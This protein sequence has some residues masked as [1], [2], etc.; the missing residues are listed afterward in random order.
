MQTL[1]F[2]FVFLGLISLSSCARWYSVSPDFERVSRSHKTIAVLPFEVIM[3][4]R[5]PKKMSEEEIIAIEEAEAQAFQISMHDEM[6]RSLRNGRFEL[7]ATLLSV[8]ETNARLNEAGLN[9]YNVH[10]MSPRD[11]CRAL[12]VDAVYL[13]RVEKHRFLTDLESF[14]IDIAQD[15]LLIL[16]RGNLW[17]FADD[18][19][20]DIFVQGTI[21]EGKNGQA[22]FTAQRGFAVDWTNPSSQII[23]NINYQIAKRIPYRV[24]N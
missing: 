23:R 3:T 13:G 18:T 5:I 8:Q 12:N 9:I 4:G 6:L 24:R 16:S 11:L 15:L 21:L 22:L 7:S 17:L 10:N 1:K 2:I 20:Q 19:A 14:G